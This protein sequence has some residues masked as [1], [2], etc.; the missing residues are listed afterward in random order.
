MAAI[1]GPGGAARIRAELAEN[2]G[3]LFEWFVEGMLYREL[4]LPALRGVRLRTSPVGGDLEYADE[5]TLG[6]ALSGRAEV[7]RGEE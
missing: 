4:A 2:L 1:F 5:L 7:R 6:R 3:G